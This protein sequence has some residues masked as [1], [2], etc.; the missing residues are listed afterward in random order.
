MA[1]QDQK[2]RE[3]C[4]DA[5]CYGVVISKYYPERRTGKPGMQQQS[6][7]SQRVGH[8]CATDQNKDVSLFFKNIPKQRQNARRQDA[9]INVWYPQ[10]PS[11]W[12][13]SV[14]FFPS[15]FAPTRSWRLLQALSTYSWPVSQVSGPDQP[16][17]QYA[18]L[19][20]VSLTFCFSIISLNTRFIS[21]VDIQF[22]YLFYM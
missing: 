18:S 17:L 16:V 9:T 22:F 7:G 15:S 8:N 10:F 13:T 21:I 19:D 6:M 12:L 14:F 4:R 5:L 11:R 1:E 2:E 20:Q 3:D